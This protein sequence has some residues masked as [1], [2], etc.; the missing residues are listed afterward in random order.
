MALLRKLWWLLRRRQKEQEL[1]EEMQFHID[2]DIEERRASGRELHDAQY[3]ARREFGNISL[4]QEQTRETWGWPFLDQFIQDSRYALR[5]LIANR[6]FTALAALSLALGLGANTALFSFLDAVLLRSLRVRDP[7]S[8]AVL[9]WRMKRPDGGNFQKNGPAS[10]MYAMNG[11]THDDVDDGW[12][13]DIF[14]YPSFELLRSAGSPFANVFAWFPS[15]DLNVVLDGQSE[16]VT[17]TYVSGE[18]FDVLGVIPTAGRFINLDDDRASVSPVAVVSYVYSQGHFAHA[19]DAVGQHVLLNNVPFTI[20]GVA[21]ENFT[22]VD[23]AAA[24][25]FFVPLQTLVLLESGRNASKQVF[26]DENYYWLRMMGRLRPGVTRGQAESALSVPFHQWAVGT[27]HNLLQ[28]SNLPVLRLYDGS[29][30]SDSLRRR[31]ARPL[32]VLFLMVALILAVACANIANLLMA[33]GSSRRRE[34]ALRLSLGASRFRIL[35]QLLTESVMLSI[36][37]GVLSIAVAVNAVHFITILL[38]NNVDA[39]GPVA[40][41]PHAELNWHVFLAAVALSVLTGLLFGALPAL[42]STHI[43]LLPGLKN[44]RLGGLHRHSPFAVSDVLMVF[45]ITMSLVVLVAAGLFAAT[46]GQYHSLSLGFNAENLLLFQVNARQGGHSGA[47]MATFYAG[48]Q[49]QLSAAPGIR[50]STLSHEPILLAGTGLPVSVSGNR[51][52]SNIMAIGPN[53]FSTMQIPVE[54]GREFESRDQAN[55]PGVAIIN[56][57]FAHTSFGTENPIGRRVQVTDGAVRE[58]E[59]VGLVHDTQYGP[60]GQKTPPVLFIPYN[61]GTFQLID[62]MTFAVRTDGEPLRYSGIVRQIVRQADSNV[63]VANIQSQRD[64]IDGSLSQETM[65]MQLCTALAAIALAIACVGIYATVSYN[66]S[67]RTSEIGIRMALG[68]RERRV[69]YLVVRRILV[70]AFVGLIVGL[71]L[72]LTVSREFES[73]LFETKPNDPVILSAAIAILGLS[74]L[75]AALLPAR[76]AARIDP[77]IALRHE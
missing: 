55:S 29:A 63:P 24:P 65:F 61:Q 47:E 11:S 43:D 71:P 18:Y 38:K 14:P 12:V 34:I 16:L 6:T 56:E 58:V 2:E 64:A 44:T 23:P 22:G 13:G 60:L 15:R 76:R 45:Q 20:A 48:I 69:I 3:D 19:I 68:A 28:Q 62:R 40:V 7:Q 39:R 9:S 50:A 17:G 30:G 31:F 35:R 49:K 25:A 70:C 59:I 46:L 26:I 75:V 36:V 27:A 5:S 10:V 37:G 33:R 1:Q 67:R 8:L 52:R 53:Y 72:I 4:L 42:E 66:V 21:P 32:E 51:I 74:S 54:L 73:Y 57:Q 41:P 77:V